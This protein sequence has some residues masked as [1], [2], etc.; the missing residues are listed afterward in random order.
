MKKRK[1]KN[2]FTKVRGRIE[3]I[4]W[5]DN[6]SWNHCNFTIEG[7]STDLTFGPV[8]ESGAMFELMASHGQVRSFEMYEKDRW[9][10]LLED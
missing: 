1:R 6:A 5:H 3:S 8:D 7:I 9:R 2:E 10:M 4:R